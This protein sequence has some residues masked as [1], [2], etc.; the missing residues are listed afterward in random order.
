MEQTSE[1]SP[2]LPTIDDD[3]WKERLRAAVAEVL[4]RRQRKAAIRAD[5]ARTRSYGLE[6]RHT[7]KLRHN[8]G[9]TKEN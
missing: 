1:G 2:T 8:A 3:E 5:L 4:A 9:D 6:A 7:N